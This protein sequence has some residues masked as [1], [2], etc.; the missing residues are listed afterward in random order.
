MTWPNAFTPYV[1]PML[2]NVDPQDWRQPG[3][4]AISDHILSHVFPGAIVLMHDGGGDR[5]QSVAALEII[6]RGLSAKGPK[7]YNILGN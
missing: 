4:K 6:L 7:F 2:W 5:T 3:T 1:L